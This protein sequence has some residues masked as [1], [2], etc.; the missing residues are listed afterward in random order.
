MQPRGTSG[1][2]I[3]TDDDII[4]FWG[5]STLV[6]W[7]RDTLE[8]QGLA[9]DAAW[10]L[11]SVGLPSVADFYEAMSYPPEAECTI[12]FSGH[13]SER[14]IGTERYLQIGT[15]VYDSVCLSPATS[16]VLCVSALDELQMMNSGVRSLARCLVEFIRYRRAI[17]HANEEAAELLARET[18]N[19]IREL[20]P[21]VV[22]MPESWWSHII[23][24]MED[25]FL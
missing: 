9:S 5:P 25:G 16:N 18:I 6:R 8:A 17:V 22:A 20:D 14:R 23:G 2:V 3:M 24:Q 21:H 10:F 7:N 13:L 11:A 4:A 12:R 19:R 1:T 15:A